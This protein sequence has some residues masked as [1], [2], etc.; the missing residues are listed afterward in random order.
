MRILPDLFLFKT[1]IFTHVLLST[2]S[3]IFSQQGPV[4]TINLQTN[5]HIQC[6]LQLIDH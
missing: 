2:G 3:S 6:C 4:F 1:D 5:E